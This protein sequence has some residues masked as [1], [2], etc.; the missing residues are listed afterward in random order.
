MDRLLLVQIA[1]A[2]IEVALMM[3]LARGALVLLFLSAPQRLESNFIYQMFVKGSQPL[4]HAIRRIAPRVVLDRHLPYAAIGL[5]LAVWIG[6]S[7]A[8]LRICAENVDR[9][10]CE[11]LLRHRALT[12]A[13]DAPR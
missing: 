13:A 1:K 11:N 6:L 12:P 3:F 9:P 8:K 4:V 5:L 10:A 7:L 2:V